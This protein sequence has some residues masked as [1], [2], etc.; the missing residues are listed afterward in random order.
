MTKRRYDSITEDVKR[1]KVS[2]KKE[3]SQD[4]RIIQRYDAL[5]VEGSEKL[6]KT[7]SKERETV[8]KFVHADELFDVFCSNYFSISHGRRHRIIMQS[9]TLYKNITQAQIK[10]FLYLCE[11]S[12]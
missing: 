5:I 9:N 1:I 11:S 7:L 4:Y 3:S 8:K 10:M 6:I 2:K 12:Q